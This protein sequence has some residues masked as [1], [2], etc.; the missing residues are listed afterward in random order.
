[1]SPRS[2]LSGQ[3]YAAAVVAATSGGVVINPDDT[4][5]TKGGYVEFIAATAFNASGLL[6]SFLK[7]VTTVGNH[8]M[9]IAVG[10]A[11]SEQ[12]IVADLLFQRQTSNAHSSILIPVAIP[13]GVRISAREQCSSASETSSEFTMHIIAADADENFGMQRCVTY[14]AD[15]SDTGG[16]NIDPG[17]VGNTKGSY[18]EVTSATTAAIKWLIVAIGNKKNAGVTDCRWL[19]DIA[20]G[21]A[22]SEQ[23]IIPDLSLGTDSAADLFYPLFLGLPVDIPLGSRIAVRAQCSITDA[24]DRLFD[25]ILYGVG[26]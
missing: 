16:L 2:L 6:V 10:A 25:I 4:A 13:A 11:A 5:H 18:V 12:I 9:D 21:A 1:M 24:T 8:L 3:R 20:I 26:G 22:A 14:G 19:M 7:N 15:T 23:I 17:A